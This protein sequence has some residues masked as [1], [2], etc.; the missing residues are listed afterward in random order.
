MSLRFLEL[1]ESGTTYRVAFSVSEFRFYVLDRSLQYLLHTSSVAL[2]QLSGSM[3]HDP[4][5][6]ALDRAGTTKCVWENCMT[7]TV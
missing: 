1:S 2:E 5:L 7:C 6:A 4:T 3:P